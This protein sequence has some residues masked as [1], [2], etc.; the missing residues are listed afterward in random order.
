MIGSAST[1]RP[2]DAG[3][4]I[5]NASRIPRASSLR[6]AIVLPLAASLA[7]SGSATVPRATPK[8]PS[9]SCIRRNATV[10]QNVGPS[11]SCDANIE[12]ISTF[13]WVVLAATTD[14]PIRRKIDLTPGSRQWK[15]GRNA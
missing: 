12:L 14:G 15:S 13:T 5:R 11:P 10:S 6:K 8:M 2:T 1:I 4:V 9:G 7:S 3:I